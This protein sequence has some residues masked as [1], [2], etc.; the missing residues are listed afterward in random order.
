MNTQ[1]PLRS[2]RVP[3]FVE[4]YCKDRIGNQAAMRAGYT[5]NPD[6]AAVIAARLLSDVRVQ[7][8]IA[9]EMER[10][11]KEAVVD[12]AMILKEY[13]SLATADAS[14]IM[15]VRHVNCRHCW[16]TNYLY[17]WKAREYAE[18]CDW[19]LK[20]ATK[21]KREVCMPDCG[22]GFGFRRTREPNAE[23]PECEGD[24]IDDI[25]F[26]DTESLTGAERKLIA[27]I[28]RTKDGLEIKMRDQDGALKIL[29]QYA[30][31]L[32]DRKELTGKNGQPLVPTTPPVDLPSDAGQLGALYSRIVG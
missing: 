20:T 22:G 19:E 31:L 6:S 3:R 29:A 13:L 15:H 28:K 5:Q 23:C 21:E 32:I 2:K 17:Q 12:A 27:G 9:V 18:Q 4:E 11:S 25:V 30:G 8:L 14:K 10:V 26:G 7:A 16:G 1:D 24:G